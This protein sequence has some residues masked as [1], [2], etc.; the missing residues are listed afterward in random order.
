M[1]LVKRPPG[2]MLRVG[3][4]DALNHTRS[5]VFR[6]FASPP[7]NVPLVCFSFSFRAF[8]AFF[9]FVSSFLVI[10][11]YVPMELASAIKPKSKGQLLNNV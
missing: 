8:W 11:C 3:I 6:G 2:I 10:D 4:L 9:H 5:I 1:S 7:L